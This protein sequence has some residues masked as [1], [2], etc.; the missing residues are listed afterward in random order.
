MKKLVYT[1]MFLF[2]FATISFA[3]EATEI[4]MTEGAVELEYSKKD[5]AYTFILNGKAEADINK[6]A[7]YYTNYFTLKFDESSQLVNLV[8]VDNTERSRAVIVRFLVSSGVRHANVDGK[9]IS[10]ND[11]MMNY[12]Q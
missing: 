5:G 1:L 3:Q 10:I 8:M 9:V 12:L 11:F 7:N 6:S 4:V 2:G